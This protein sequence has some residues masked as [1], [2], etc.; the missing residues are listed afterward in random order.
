MKAKQQEVFGSFDVE[1]LDILRGN[2]D[3]LYAKIEGDTPAKKII[4]LPFDEFFGGLASQ[5]EDFTKTYDYWL[6]IKEKL[7]KVKSISRRYAI[8]G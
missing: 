8:C 3:K 2:L 4:N 1:G 6:E 5:T 7:A